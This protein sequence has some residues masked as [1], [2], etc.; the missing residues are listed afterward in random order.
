VE[1][2]RVPSPDSGIS[3]GIPKG[4]LTF[5]GSHAISTDHAALR[6]RDPAKVYPDE[7]MVTVRADTQRLACIL[8]ERRTSR[9]N[10]TVVPKR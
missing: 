1:E 10:K 4:V 3:E 9:G 7:V 6:I 2:N 8:M 5:S